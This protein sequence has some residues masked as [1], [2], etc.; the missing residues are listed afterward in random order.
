MNN[1]GIPLT[2]RSMILEKFPAARKRMLSDETP[3]LEAGIID[4]L[5]VLDVVAFLEG[6]FG[7]KV[8]DEELIPDNFGSIKRLSAFVEKKQLRVLRA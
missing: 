5:G 8:E 3:L 2:I 4:S 6:N 7:M 1:A